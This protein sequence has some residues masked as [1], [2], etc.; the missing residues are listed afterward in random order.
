MA[1]ARPYPSAL[2][3]SSSAVAPPLPKKSSNGY[4]P[5]CDKCSCPFVN[6]KVARVVMDNRAAL[7]EVDPDAA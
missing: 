3:N 6:N 4:Y 7:C 2:Q 5:L 1:W